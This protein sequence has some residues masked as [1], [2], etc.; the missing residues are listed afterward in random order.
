[1][2]QS[3]QFFILFLVCTRPSGYVHTYKQAIYRTRLGSRALLSKLNAVGVD[4][5]RPGSLYRRDGP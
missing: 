4:V 3:R 5:L 1:M 2:Y